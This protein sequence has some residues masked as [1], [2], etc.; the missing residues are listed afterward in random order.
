MSTED[1]AP[2]LLIA[3]V[4]A[5]HGWR[6]IKQGWGAFKASPWQWMLTVVVY[7]AI[8]LGLN[9]VWVLGSVV[10]TLISPILLA[11]LML[12][13]H[14]QARGEEDFRVGFL[15]SAFRRP[16]K[17]MLA[18]AALVVVLSTLLMLPMYL[19]GGNVAEGQAYGVPQLLGLFVSFLLFVPLLMATLFPPALLVFYPQLKAHQAMWL[20][21]WACYR[22]IL[23][24]FSYGLIALVLLVAAAIPMLLG[25]LVV[26]PVLIASVY[27][28]YLDLFTA[29]IPPLSGGE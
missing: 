3:R 16:L 24:F 13:C 18:Y 6:W 12:G 29:E 9:L 5:S 14:A 7:F 8:T 28:A 11:G 17:S 23:P 4:D 26:M 25:M 15:F 10:E 19:I 2:Q 21:F 20:S 22:N 1:K 27:F